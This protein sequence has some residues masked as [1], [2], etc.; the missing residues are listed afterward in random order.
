MGLLEELKRTATYLDDGTYRA[1]F[2]YGTDDLRLEILETA[3]LL[4]EV[5][6]KIEEILTDLMVRKGFG[7][8][9]GPSDRD[10]PSA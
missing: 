5:A 1:Q 6:E 2:E 7:V 10:D 3:D 4:F 8:A 9:A